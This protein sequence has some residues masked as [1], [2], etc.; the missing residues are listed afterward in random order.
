MKLPLRLLLSLTVAAIGLNV[1]AA[2][3]QSYPNK[4]VHI[5]VP[6][7][8]GGSIDALARLIG[9]KLA[10]AFG[11]PVIVNNQP[12]AGGTIGAAQVARSAPDG[13]TILL[14]PVNLAMMPALYR[15]LPF[16]AAMDFIPVTQL[17]ATELVLVA[18]PQL[19]ATSVKEL[20]ALSK[21]KPGSLNF[22][23]TG[24]AS[25]LHLTMELLKTS[26]GIDIMAIPYKGD[27]P[28]NTAL[29]SGEVELAVM[30]V[31]AA[32]QYIQK[33]RLRALGMTGP[34]RAA[35][36]PEVPTIS[37]SGIAGFEITSWQGLF[38]PANTPRDIV[39]RIQAEAA[40]ALKMPDVRER[41]PA[42]GQLPVG[43][44]PDEFSAKFRSDIT[45]FAGI[46]KAARIPFQD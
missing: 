14:M 46:V 35:S 26:A 37:E 12:G 34:R 33:G 8:A 24:V 20:I 19:P 11:Q 27:G 2:L 7:A 5:V 45:K 4:P 21:A 3:G 1:G 16:D 17:I 6:F 9:P 10:A 15:K 43:S 18:N 31:S 39:L 38:V 13:H 36:F 40:K 23:S 28:L 42:L 25:P 22:G 44:T 41:L 32:Q 29:M 30:P